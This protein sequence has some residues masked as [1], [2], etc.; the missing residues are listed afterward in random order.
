[1]TRAGVTT[2]RGAGAVAF[3]TGGLTGFATGFAVGWG[4]ALGVGCTLDS[5]ANGVDNEASAWL[6][7]TGVVL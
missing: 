1:M 2:G 5:S 7:A 3:L 4:L 6:A